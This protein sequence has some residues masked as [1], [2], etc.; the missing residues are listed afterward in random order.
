MLA[1]IL[2]VFYSMCAR[3]V[4]LGKSERDGGGGSLPVPY[5]TCSV[6]CYRIRKLLL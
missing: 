1:F 5:V 6:L 3:V 2:C 4:V